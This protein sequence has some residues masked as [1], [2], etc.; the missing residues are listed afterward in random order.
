MSLFQEIKEKIEEF[1]NPT[2][3]LCLISNEEKDTVVITGEDLE[4]RLKIIFDDGLT[5]RMS[6]EYEKRKYKKEAYN[7]IELSSNKEKHSIKKLFYKEN[8]RGDFYYLLK[9]SSK[10]GLA[11]QHTDISFS[12]TG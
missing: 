11:N 9:S 4:K 12:S 1:K 8:D 7:V 3:K 10:N 5:E 6:S 2:F